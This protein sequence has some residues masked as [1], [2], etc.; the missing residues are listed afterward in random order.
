VVARHAIDNERAF[1]DLK[2]LGESLQREAQP[3]EGVVV[4]LER[5]DWRVL[6]AAESTTP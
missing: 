6:H 2:R 3:A 5:S 1:E 4:F